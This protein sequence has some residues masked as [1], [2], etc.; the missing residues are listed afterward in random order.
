M[1]MKRIGSLGITIV[2]VGL[3][4][5]TNAWAGV[6]DMDPPLPNNDPQ[7]EQVRTLWTKHYDGD[8]LDE[9][10][11]AL[12]PLKEKN[13]ER[14]EPYLW[15]ARA[16][17]LH[18][19]YHRKDRPAHFAQAEEYA[20]KACSMDAGNITAVKMLADICVYSHNR[21]YLYAH[22][23]NLIRGKAP[24]PYGEAL[25]DMPSYAGWGTFQKLWAARA[26]IEKAKAAAAMTEQ[27]AFEN[28]QDG[29][30]QIWAARANYYLGENYTSTGEHNT[31]ALPYYKQGIVYSEKA[32]A[33]IPNSVPANY[34]YQL[35]LA[36]SIQF[37]SLFN[38]GRYLMD[39]LNPLL[40]C[41]R[42]N[43][44]YYYFGPAQTL[45]TM[46]TNGGWVTEKGMQIAGISL[47]TALAG[48]ELT[49]ILY[50]D[51]YHAPYCRADVL[52]YQGKRQEALA[53]L[54][55]LLARNPDAN[56]LIPENRFFLRM[57]RTLYTDIK[58]GRR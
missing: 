16:H 2:L 23:G 58:K 38:K 26:D 55:N 30:A 51:Y 28:P 35:N 12:G 41:S 45:G 46:I 11:A 29:L 10:I 1:G 27:F 47:E 9:L 18:A 43:S 39:L 13:P 17:Y 4:L 14:V 22:Y 8:Y 7:W 49:E 6:W 3:G 50:P 48:L 34:W 57:A 19:R 37:T 40:F 15:L 53:I 31:K 24:L 5:L 25:P 36:R 44:S 42:E 32:R 52:V 56:A 54:E 20:A 21:A 33:R